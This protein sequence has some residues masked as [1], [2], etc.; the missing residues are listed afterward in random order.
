MAAAGSLGEGADSSPRGLLPMSAYGKG[1]MPGKCNPSLF[2]LTVQICELRRGSAWSGAPRGI[3]T[4]LTHT[5]G[6]YN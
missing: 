5:P 4:K 6:S 1:Q 2:C 3:Y